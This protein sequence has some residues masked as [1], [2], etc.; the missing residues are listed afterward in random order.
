MNGLAS[1]AWGL[2]VTDLEEAMKTQHQRTFLT[3]TVISLAAAAVMGV[4]AIFV[5]LGDTGS[6]VL[7]TTLLVAV[8]GMLSLAGAT[9]AAY[10]SGLGR[11]AMAAACLAL[12]PTLALIWLDGWAP[13]SGAEEWLIKS[14]GCL[15]VMAAACAHSGLLSL[16]RLG[17]LRWV[18]SATRA[19]A[20]GLAAFAVAQIIDD[21]HVGDS[22]GKIIAAGG[23][24]ATFGT[25]AVPILHR[26]SG[27]GVA[28]EL[29]T[30]AGDAAIA[31]TCP[32]C[33][34]AE[35]TKAGDSACSSCDLGFSIVLRENR[36]PCGY[37][38]YGLAG[39]T[40]PECGTA[41]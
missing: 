32:R 19:V 6:K 37:P 41:N 23:V 10:G 39:K 15:G 5:D 18:L 30:V 17:K 16:A 40:C 27:I 26:M 13:L 25:L 7:V 31:L 38:L 1:W 34:S 9:A 22:L 24:L 20:A 33:G 36:C 11:P 14:A 8:T 4:V 29:V 3:A 28:N 12:P 35:E 21:F 2:M